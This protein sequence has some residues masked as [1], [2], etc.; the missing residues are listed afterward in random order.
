MKLGRKC[1]LKVEINPLPAG[2]VV[3]GVTILEGTN[4]L[5]IS[6]DLKIEFDIYRAFQG[7]SQEGKFTIVNLNENHRNLL[8]KDA[9]ALGEFRAIQFRAGYED[10]PLALCFNG[11]VRTASSYRRSPREIVTE[12]YAYDGGQ[13]MA[14][15]WISMAL[16]P[17]VSTVEA[18]RNLAQALPGLKGDP[19]IGNFPG[20]N[21]RSKVLFGNAWN[22]ILQETGNFATIDNGQLK[23]LQLNEVIDAPVPIINADSGLLGSPRRT[24]TKLEVETLFEPRI[25][26]ASI[27]EVQSVVNRPLS[28]VY[29]VVGIH[30][31][32]SISPT[33]SG[34]CITRATLFF[35][36]NE[37]NTVK[38]KLAQ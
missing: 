36:F 34:R 11:Y 6:E 18:I 37:Y 3:D 5:T 25:E 29:K 33:E 31:S 28:G 7:A 10:E 21:L 1:E 17:G 38:G 23:A 24:P 16:G 35:G 14:N 26:L 19:I 12:I 9:Y 4:V 22:L 20:A 27:V 13:A 30:H 2:K 32:G 8:Q 15:G